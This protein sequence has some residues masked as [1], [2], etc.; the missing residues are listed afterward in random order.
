MREHLA[1]DRRKMMGRRGGKSRKKKDKGADEKETRGG[2]GLG[3]EKEKRRWR[4]NIGFK[5]SDTTIQPRSQGF[6]LGTRLPTI[7]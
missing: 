4:V 3:G 6:S 2:G 5:H 7:V 1:G